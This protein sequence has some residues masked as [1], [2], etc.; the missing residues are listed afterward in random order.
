M[1][2]LRSMSHATMRQLDTPAKYLTNGIINQNSDYTIINFLDNSGTSIA[3][4]INSGMLKYQDCSN[5]FVQFWYVVSY[6]MIRRG[7]WSI[8]QTFKR[9]FPL[10][11]KVIKHF[12]HFHLPTWDKL[13][14]QTCTFW[15]CI[16]P[17]EL[18]A[19]NK[20]DIHCRSGKSTAAEVILLTQLDILSRG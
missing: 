15:N 1:H 3:G 14:S 13:I 17:A 18:L 6:V 20:R 5:N 19:F 16:I 12:N 11:S 2:V 8:S 4:T 10:I 7:W 9:R